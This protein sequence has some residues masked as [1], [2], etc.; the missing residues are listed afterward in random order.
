MTLAELEKT[1][2]L[3]ALIAGVKSKFSSSAPSSSYKPPLNP[4]L[5]ESKSRKMVADLISRSEQR[6][7]SEPKPSILSSRPSSKS[8][9]AVETKAGVGS[10]SRPKKS[11]EGWRENFIREHVGKLK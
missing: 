6:P 1:G 9:F 5:E 2:N 11:W 4:H 10:E 8:G 3:K 7:P